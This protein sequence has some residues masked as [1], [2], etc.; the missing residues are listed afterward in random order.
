M[1][2]KQG[3]SGS[4]SVANKVSQ[5]WAPA[6]RPDL[7][8]G[9]DQPTTASSDDYRDVC[10]CDELLA[11]GSKDL[12]IRRKSGCGLFFFFCFLRRFLPLNQD[13]AVCCIEQGVG[14]GVDQPTTASSDDYR[15]ACCCDELLALGSKDLSIRRK[16][17]C[18]MFF[19]YAF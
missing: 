17:G 2:R 13:Q 3:G 15:D 10:C 6:R 9:V 19:F 7:F 16:S 8:Q 5:R 4:R 14:Q 11:L 18:G 1:D 12:S